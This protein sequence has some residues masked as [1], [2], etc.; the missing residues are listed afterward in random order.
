VVDAHSERKRRL[1]RVDL[2]KLPYFTCILCLVCVYIFYFVTADNSLITSMAW[3][4]HPFIHQ[5]ATHLWENMVELA[6][7][8]IIAESWSRATSSK[9]RYL[10]I[11]SLSYLISLVV[12]IFKFTVDKLMLLGASGLIFALWGFDLAY[13]LDYAHKS[14]LSR[15][16]ML[17]PVGIGI[18]GSTLVRETVLFLT[19][20]TVRKYGLSPHL[21][22]AAIAFVM[23]VILSNQVRQRGIQ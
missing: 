22:A 21:M 11:L 13:Y 8:G 19:D 6:I 1:V 18:V 12:M 10:A 7:V 9:T 4:L 15:A 16:W 5:D 14:N 3:F 23:G 20:A 17:V 2:R